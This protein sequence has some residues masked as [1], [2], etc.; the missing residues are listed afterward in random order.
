MH[1]RDVLKASGAGALTVA[2]PRAGYAAAAAGGFVVDTRFR[3]AEAAHAPLGAWR[4][5][6]DGD[7]TALW[8]DRLDRA[9]RRPGP[10]LAGITGEDALFVLERLA[11]DRQRRVVLREVVSGAAGPVPLVRWLIAGKPGVRA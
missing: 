5:E 3:A 1:R 11:W 8:V 4:Q 2:W 10:A 7:V 9:W 6:I